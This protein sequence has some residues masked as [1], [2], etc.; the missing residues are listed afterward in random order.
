MSV[1]RHNR[2][3]SENRDASNIAKDITNEK[4]NI[5]NNIGININIIVLNYPFY[6]DY[7]Y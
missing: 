2:E 1:D 6:I 3:E 4:P 5:F 7:D